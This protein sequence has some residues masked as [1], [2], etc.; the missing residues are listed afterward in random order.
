MQ[1]SNCPCNH[2]RNPRDGFKKDKSNQ[3]R[4]VTVSAEAWTDGELLTHCDSVKGVCATTAVVGC[5]LSAL[6]SGFIPVTISIAHLQ[7]TLASV[8]DRYHWHWETCLHT[9]VTLHAKRSPEVLGFRWLG[10]TSSRTLSSHPMCGQVR[11]G[12]ERATGTWP[13]VLGCPGGSVVEMYCC[14]KG[15]G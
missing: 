13:G 11:C 2:P 14:G 1:V 8:D 7:R 6:C 9:L 5:R 15:L 3:L 12:A 4:Q 10:T